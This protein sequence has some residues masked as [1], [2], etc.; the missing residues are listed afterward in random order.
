VHEAVKERHHPLPSDGVG[1]LK[2]RA[3]VGDG[4]VGSQGVHLR[5]DGTLSPARAVVDIVV[6]RMSHDVN[7][8]A[9]TVLEP[10]V[11]ENLLVD[12]AHHAHAVFITA[13]KHNEKSV[14]PLEH[15]RP[16]VARRC[17]QQ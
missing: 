2:S 10:S 17:S 6:D 3:R 15:L 7:K 5:V 14:G 12:R 1:P 9:R 16:G 8:D 11:P 4:H 13:L